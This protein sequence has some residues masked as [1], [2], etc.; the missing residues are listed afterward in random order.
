MGAS[1]T[2]SSRWQ[3]DYMSARLGYLQAGSC[4][5]LIRVREVHAAQTAIL[6]GTLTSPSMDRDPSVNDVGLCGSYIRESG[7]PTEEIQLIV[8]ARPPDQQL[9]QLRS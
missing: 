3:P 1:P 8:L 7:H 6:S 9:H 4:C 5:R 2:A